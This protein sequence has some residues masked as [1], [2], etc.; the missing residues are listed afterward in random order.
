MKE[1]NRRFD[2]PIQEIRKRNRVP[3]NV[4]KMRRER[5]YTLEGITNYKRKR[6]T[7]YETMSEQIVKQQIQKF[8]ASQQTKQTNLPI[9]KDFRTGSP[10]VQQIISLEDLG[11]TVQVMANEGKLYLDPEFPAA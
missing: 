7:I 9:Q 10:K 4:A 11:K 8:L 5:E 1:A 2:K 3:E 6:K